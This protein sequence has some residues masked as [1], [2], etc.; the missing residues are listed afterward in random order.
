MAFI[1]LIWCCVS[2]LL[3]LDVSARLQSTKSRNQEING[4]NAF[5]HSPKSTPNAPMAFG[6]Y[7][8]H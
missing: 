4:M 2:A 8:Y 1:P 7:E 5:W 6:G 3:G